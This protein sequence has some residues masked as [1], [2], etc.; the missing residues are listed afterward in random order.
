MILQRLLDDRKDIME[1]ENNYRNLEESRYRQYFH[2]EPV[3]GLLNDPNGFSYHKGK[4]TLFY[5]WSPFDTYHALKHWYRTESD[6]LIYF[7]NMGLGLLPEKEF[8]NH[9][10]YSGTGL[11]IDGH[12]NIFYTGNYRDKEN[13]RKPKQIRAMVENDKVTNKEIIIP[14]NEM[15]TEHQRDPSIYFNK[16]DGLYYIFL[17]VQSKEKKGGLALYRSEDLDQWKYLGLVNVH[18]YED[19]GYMWEC[20]SFANIDG[21]DLLIFSPQGVDRDKYGFGNIDN[22]GYLI[23]KMDFDNLVF[24][25]DND[26]SLLD[27]GFEFYASQLS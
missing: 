12:L 26:F 3:S 23:G 25:P 20:P 17:G 13:V 19:Y 6:D 15:F 16:D 11:S 2:V 9:G 27:E 21:K 18:G 24:I 5:Q 14:T 7:E 8:E 10:A 1:L 22:N 4:R